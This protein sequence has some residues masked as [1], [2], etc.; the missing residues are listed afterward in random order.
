MGRVLDPDAQNRP[1]EAYCVRCQGEL[2]GKEAEPDEMGHT[3]CPECKDL[4]ARKRDPETAIAV[5]EAYDQEV[6][7][8]CSEDVR[9]TIWNALVMRFPEVG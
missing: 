8:Y 9:N 3:L 7:K 1:P 2:W 6:A 5:M 4:I